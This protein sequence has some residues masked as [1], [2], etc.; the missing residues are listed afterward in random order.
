[1]QLVRVL[2]SGSGISK[3]EAFGALGPSVKA[4]VFGELETIP[5]QEEAFGGSAV[6]EGREGHGGAECS[7]RLP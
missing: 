6:E 1:M 4:N 3:A 5:K 7:P 2:Y